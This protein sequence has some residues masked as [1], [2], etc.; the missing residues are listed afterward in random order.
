MLGRYADTHRPPVTGGWG[1]A[2]AVVVIWLALAGRSV[3]APAAAAAEVTLRGKV[4]DVAGQPIAGVEVYLYAD[5]NTR[6]PADFISPKSDAEGA[7]RLVVPPGKYLAVARARTGPGHGPLSPTDRHSGAPKQIVLA[8]G[9][10]RTVNFVVA[11]LREAARR[12]PKIRTDHFT[13]AGRILDADG[14][15]LAR[16]YVTAQRDG[17]T[18]ALPDYFSAWTA[19]DGRYVIFVPRGRYRLA[20]AANFPPPS[21][22]PDGR[23]IVVT[24]DQRG[25]D[26]AGSWVGK[27]ETPRAKP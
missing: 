6:R 21:S 11:S 19:A 20:P 7:Y 3:A 9:A 8:D 12:E 18:R 27:K 14:A 15:P 22:R 1:H 23:L 4:A 17:S 24:G 13:I 10:D 16:A 25:V 2:A 26:F 5:P